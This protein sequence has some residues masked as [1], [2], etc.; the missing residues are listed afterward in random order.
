MLSKSMIIGVQML[1]ALTKKMI[2]AL[3]SNCNELPLGK[4]L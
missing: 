2:F 4:E 3:I 1:P